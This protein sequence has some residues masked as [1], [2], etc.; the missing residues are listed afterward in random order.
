MNDTMKS[1]A[2]SMMQTA[3]I[4]TRAPRKRLTHLSAMRPPM[5]VPGIPPRMAS[6]PKVPLAACCERWSWFW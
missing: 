1:A 2:L 3:G 5:R 4:T 6:A